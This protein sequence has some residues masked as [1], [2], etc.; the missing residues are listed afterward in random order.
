MV[1]EIKAEGSVLNLQNYW[2]DKTGHYHERQ[3]DYYVQQGTYG[4][5]VIAKVDRETQNCD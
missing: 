1:D 5:I 2:R 4:Q 3:V